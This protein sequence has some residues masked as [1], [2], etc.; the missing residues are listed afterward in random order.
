MRDVHGHCDE[1]FELVR[2]V[3]GDHLDTG[4]DVGASVA[5]S[6][7]GELVIDLWG[8]V[9]DA[10]R[11]T[12]WERDTITHLWST[13]KAVTALCVLILADRG[14][15]DL[16]SPVARYWPEFAAA[17]K[18][19][20]R[21]AHVLG[22]TSGVS[23]WDVTVTED[24]LYDHEKVA[25]LLAAQTPWW[26]PGTASGY[27]ALTQGYLLDEIVR[28]VTGEGIGAFVANEIAGPLEADFHIGLAS[29]HHHRVADVIPP[30]TPEGGLE[31][32]PTSIAMRTLANPA[33]GAEVSLTQRWREAEIAAVNGHGN[34]RS[35]ATILAALACQGMA[36]D[37]RLMSAKGS[38]AVF[39]QQSDGAD[40]VLGLPLRRG[41]GLALNGPGLSLGPGARTCFW[42]GWGGSLVLADPDA[43]LA[44]AYVMNRMGEGLIGDERGHALVDATYRALIHEFHYSSVR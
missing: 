10:A 17:G 16:D 38:E 22:H 18:Q 15:L 9:T 13:T 21:V 2:A 27:H 28:R 20:V 36:S 11:G 44:F 42:G 31:L 33:M 3:F 8:G 41:T 29:E 26:Q 5:I 39:R 43:R 6:L 32:D 7:D 25:G 40:L 12:P 37:I 34:A 30:P 1:R 4:L 24:D 23:G 14:E 35:V 19:D